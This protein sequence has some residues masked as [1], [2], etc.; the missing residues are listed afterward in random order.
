MIGKKTLNDKS[1]E[2]MIAE[3]IA[4][5]PF[6]SDEWTNYNLSDPGITMLENLTAFT[7]LQREEM[8]DVSDAVKSR[9]LGLAG[10]FSREGRPAHALFQGSGKEDF[11][12]KFYQNQKMYAQE[13]CYELDG[14]SDFELGKINGIYYQSAGERKDYTVLTENFGVPKGLAIW[15]AEPKAGAELYFRLDKIPDIGKNMIFYVKIQEEFIR[16]RLSEQDEN[17]FA[18]IE[19]AVYT[20]EGY[21]NIVVRDC[22]A[23]FLFSGGIYIPVPEGVKWN[24]KEQGFMIRAVLKRADYDIPP[25]AVSIAGLLTE[26]IQIDTKGTVLAFEGAEEI[27]INHYLLQ[28]GRFFVY[29]KE[30]DGCYHP[31]YENSPVRGYSVKRESAG[32]VRISF[33]IEKLYAPIVGQEKGILINIC[34]EDL[35]VHRQLGIVYGYDYQKIS[36]LPIQK[37]WKDRLCIIAECKNE[38]GVTCHF[39]RPKSGQSKDLVYQ[40]L[41]E[42]NAIEILN[43]VEFEGAKLYLAECV[44]YE[45]AEGNV[46]PGNE[47]EITCGLNKFNCYHYASDDRGL[48]TESVEDVRKRFVKEVY[49]TTSLVTNEDCEQLVRR[50]PGLSVHKVKA[51]TDL[52]KNSVTIVLKPNSKEALPK[53]SVLYRNIV[54]R[55]LEQYRMLTTRILVEEPM[56][57]PIDVHAVVYMEKYFT[58]GKAQIERK[59]RELLD[60]T[61]DRGNFGDLISYREI[62]H[63]I[64]ALDCVKEIYEL[65]LIPQNQYAVSRVGLDYRLKENCLCYP[66]MISVEL[67]LR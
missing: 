48:D 35:L 45:G 9:L 22:T 41:E 23:G 8:D 33:A 27:L 36:L 2:Q 32:Q 16:N 28:M 42:E 7:A 12:G 31:Y 49:G 64:E 4:Q 14:K 51:I 29:V 30:A 11:A 66:G 47:F 54:S 18:E 65:N 52:Q 39:A 46:R 20:E 37:I 38:N 53:V 26:A 58:N 10:F 62:Y 40:Y 24:E 21:K 5:I 43:G 60:Y 67:N 13:L 57:V 1:Y 34:K 55:Y 63:E 50:I 59:L 15:G 25:K 19:W 3:A 17:P 61:K 56:Y 44:L 6:Y